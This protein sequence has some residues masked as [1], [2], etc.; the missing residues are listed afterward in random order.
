MRYSYPKLHSIKW[1]GKFDSLPSDIN[2]DNVLE[3][4]KGIK[5]VVLVGIDRNNELYI[6][7]SLKSD[8]E[9]IYLLN[10]AHSIILGMK[11]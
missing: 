9:S 7:S 4:A 6:V 2:A 10:K 8:A 3:R 5:S 11:Y 1:K